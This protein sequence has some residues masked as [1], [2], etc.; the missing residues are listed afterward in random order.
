MHEKNAS[1]KFPVD[2]IEECSLESQGRKFF[3]EEVL[4]FSAYMQ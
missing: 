1:L 2:T 4:R 3:K